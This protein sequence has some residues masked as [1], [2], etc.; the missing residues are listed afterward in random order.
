MMIG[1]G[2]AAKCFPPVFNSFLE[3]ALNGQKHMV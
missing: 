1:E 3:D 2:A